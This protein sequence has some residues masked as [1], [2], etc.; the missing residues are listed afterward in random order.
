LQNGGT[1]WLT[2]IAATIGVFSLIAGG[3]LQVGDRTQVW[4]T[5]WLGDMIG[6]IVLTPCL[7]LCS[8]RPRFQRERRLIIQDMTLI[9]CLLFVGAFVFG[10]RLP[11]RLQ[12]YSLAFLCIP[13]VVLGAFRLRPQEAATAIVA[14]SGIAIWGTLRGIGGFIAENRNES[15]LLLQM[16][17]GVVSMTSLLVS[18]VVLQRNSIQSSLR[19]ARDELE[20]RVEERSAQ[21]QQ[22][23]SRIRE[24]S[25][26]LLQIQDEERRRIARDLHDSTGQSLVSLTMK[27]DKLQKDA[28]RIDAGLAEGI[29]NNTELVRQLKRSSNGFLPSASAFAR[30][31]RSC[32][33]NKLVC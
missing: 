21:L 15:L 19:A 16:F 14:L 20:T 31:S 33:R 6:A 24:L 3:L 8:L 5:W 7:I 4:L 28:E 13:L 23:I 18:A 25:A 17:M 1:P 22:Q 2:G 32:S 29:S 10:G 30:R 11:F 9:L 27:L 26:R 12:N